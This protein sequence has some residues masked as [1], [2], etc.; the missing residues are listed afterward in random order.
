MPVFLAPVP[1]H[2]HKAVAPFARGFLFDA[3]IDFSL[4]F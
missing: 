3:F 4:A 1:Q 2:A